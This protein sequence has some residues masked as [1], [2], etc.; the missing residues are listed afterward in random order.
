MVTFT[1][2]T[3]P[4]RAIAT[5]C[6]RNFTRS[7]LELGG[8]YAAIICEDPVLD[9]VMAHLPIGAFG[10]SG[11]FCLSLRRTYAHRSLFDAVLERLAHADRG[12]V[13]GD[14]RHDTTQRKRRG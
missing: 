8:K 4:W 11:Q 2:S 3:A 12:F 5:S 10:N 6:A 13:S 14:P 9:V 1:G 7:S